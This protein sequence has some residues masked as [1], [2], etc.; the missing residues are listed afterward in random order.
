MTTRVRDGFTGQA[1]DAEIGLDYFQARYYGAAFGRFTSPDPGNAGADLSNPQSWNGYAYVGN[2]PLNSTDPT[3]FD[4]IKDPPPIPV[5]CPGC[6]VPVDGG[7]PDWVYLWWFYGG[8]SNGLAWGSRPPESGGNTGGGATF[9]ITHTET[10]DKSA[11]KS[12]N[13][14][15]PAVIQAATAVVDF[16]NPN[17]LKYLY[18]GPSNAYT[19]DFSKS[20]AMYRINQQIRRSCSNSS[21]KA[22]VGTA[23]AFLLTVG[24]ALSGNISFSEAQFG[25]FTASYRLNGSQ[26]E[27]NVQNVINT[28]SLLFH[29]PSDLSMSG[30]IADNIGRYGSHGVGGPVTQEMTITERNPCF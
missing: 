25:A 9:S 20:S 5:S 17:G 30:S 16:M 26:A 3:G 21:G 24:D 29:I 4:P 11:P 8:P 12:S 15:T 23:M 27:I 1:R 22:Y 10:L 6:T 13:Q 28:N 7:S 14:N 2:N 19:K 18:Y